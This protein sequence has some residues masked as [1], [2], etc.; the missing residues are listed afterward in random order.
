MRFRAHTVATA[1]HWHCLGGI[2]NLG[3]TNSTEGR[4]RRNACGHKQLVAVDTEDCATSSAHSVN[5]IIAV[6][7]ETS[8]FCCPR[9]VD[10]GYWIFKN[11][12][13]FQIGSGSASVQGNKS[14]LADHVYIEYT[15][16]TLV[17]IITA[18][19][20]KSHDSRIRWASD[21]MIVANLCTGGWA[22]TG[23]KPPKSGNFC[24]AALLLTCERVGYVAM[25]SSPLVLVISFGIA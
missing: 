3:L 4:P 16:S 8:I 9:W 18:R 2:A 7:C 15:Y 17:V 1:L 5:E 20:Q 11:T 23:R 19:E 25:D 14:P 12:S 6:G 13:A 24:R 22:M 21:S 10:Y